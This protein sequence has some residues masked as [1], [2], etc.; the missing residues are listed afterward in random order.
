YQRSAHEPGTDCVRSYTNCR[1][2]LG[3]RFAQSDQTVFRR[4]I[5]RFERTGL[6]RVDRTHINDGAAASLIAHAAQAGARGEERAVE[7]DRKHPTPV[8]KFQIDQRRDV[9]HAGVG[10]E[11]VDAF[12]SARDLR[13]PV[14]HLLLVGDVHLH[15]D[16]SGS[17]RV[18]GFLG[19]LEVRDRDPSPLLQEALGDRP[20][21]SARGPGDQR[22]LSLQHAH[23]GLFSTRA[24]SPTIP[25][26]NAITQTTKMTPWTTV[27]QEPSWAR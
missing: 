15:A 14:L 16:R 19:A 22:D 5:R 20:A 26:R 27:T 7:M 11:H 21:E 3:D 25:R 2:L 4:D 13:D 18:R 23:S 8:G 12:E 6:L 9:L 24:S 1:A 17:E 10:D